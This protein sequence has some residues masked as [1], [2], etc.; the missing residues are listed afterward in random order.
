MRVCSAF[1]VRDLLGEKEGAAARLRL[2]GERLLPPL[3]LW[4][5]APPTQGHTVDASRPDVRASPRH[6]ARLASLSIGLLATSRRTARTSSDEAGAH[7][8]RWYVPDA[9]GA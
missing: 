5:E 8:P 2:A 4:F 1:S 7:E 3:M 6:D 9:S